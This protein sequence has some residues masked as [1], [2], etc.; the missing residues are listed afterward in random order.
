MLAVT[1]P[2]LYEESINAL[3]QLGYVALEEL[4]AALDVEQETIVTQRVRRAILGIVPFPGEELVSVLE[5]SSAAQAEQIMSIFR[6]Q[7]PDA[8]VVL[9]KHLLHLDERVRDY[10]HQTLEQMPGPIVVPALL[11]VLD[12]PALR[13]IASSFLLKYPDA[14][15]SP[16]VDLLGEHERSATAAAILPQFGP[17]ILGPLLA[18]LDD[19]RSMAREL[20]QRIVVTLVRQSDN[21]Q[22]VLFEI[23][24]LFNPPPPARAREALIAVLTNELADCSLPALLEGLEDA[25]LIDDVSD[26]L[27]QLAQKA[28]MQKGVMDQLVQAL[29]LDERRRGAEMALIKIGATA[30]PV[31]GALITASDPAVARSAQDILCEI[32][33]PALPFIW[34]VHSDKSD[35]A[36]RDAAIEIF[37]RMPTDVIKDELIA[38]LLSQKNDDTAMAVSLLLERLH[39]ESTRDYADH[40]M[41]PELIEYVQTHTNEEMNLRIMALLFLLGEADIA[42]HLIQALDEHPQPVQRQLTYS[43]LLLGTKTQEL[44]FDVFQDAQTAKELRFDVAAL[45][46]MTTS[47]DLIADYA[48]NI[49]KFGMSASRTSQLFSDELSIALRAL[50]GLL[51]GGQWHPRKLQEMRDERNP[52]DASYELFNELLGWRYEPQI[53]KLQRDLDEQRDTF[54]K[55]ILALTVRAATEEKRANAL[56]DELEQIRTEH[57]SRGDQLQRVTRDRD[58]LRAGLD[59]AAKDKSAL[60]VSIDQLTKEKAALSVQLERAKLDYQALLRQNQLNTQQPG[61][62]RIF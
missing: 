15:I 52:G 29:Y 60:R 1:N 45:L 21:E 55:E 31:V 53:A 16:L 34:T 28:A 8:A 47:S 56:D 17:I 61:G 39:D 5:Q 24:Q 11:Y 2:Q 19:Q 13:K 38:L 18:G 44:L 51:A 42:D 30:V 12:Q 62:T 35:Q 23:V 54:K 37:H 43:L 3:S 58:S 33:V 9:V 25:Y 59:Q 22:A 40:V 50:G 57:S 6:M 49:S 27:A 36:R 32:G 46:G 41:V 20:S 26:A 14:A 4:V 7:G 48:Q 10:I